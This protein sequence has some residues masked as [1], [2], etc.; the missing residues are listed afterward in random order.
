MGEGAEGLV[1]LSGTVFFLL[2]DL[3]DISNRVNLHITSGHGYEKRCI[4]AQVAYCRKL[5]VHQYGG[6]YCK[7]TLEEGGGPSLPAV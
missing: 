2:V 7:T 3:V 1:G 6:V 5:Q 4:T